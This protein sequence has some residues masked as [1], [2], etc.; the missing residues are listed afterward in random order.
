MKTILTGNV[1]WSF[2]FEVLQRNR[3]TD[4]AFHFSG[5]K[6]FYAHAGDI[7][8]TEKS[9]QITGSDELEIL[10][11]DLS[12]LYLGFDDVYTMMLSKNFGLF[13]QP[14]RLTLNDDTVLY[15]II[16]YNFTGTK[17]KLWFTKLKEMLSW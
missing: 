10:L 13:W 11:G 5:V 15:L 4:F 2:D 8:L 3:N 14:L 6:P 9:I 17:N 7:V 12:Q 1:L 16:D